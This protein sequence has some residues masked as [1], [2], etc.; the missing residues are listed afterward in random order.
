MIG[1]MIPMFVALAAAESG[2]STNL[3]IPLFVICGIAMV[4]IAVVS[5]WIYLAGI[6]KRLHDRNKSGHW[7]WVLLIPYI[8]A[9]WMLIECG[10]LEGM[11]G[12]PNRYGS[13]PLSS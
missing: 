11:R 8:G 12:Q 7:A 4:A 3:N 2:E 5:S 10:C 9:F 1:P 6:V 13:D